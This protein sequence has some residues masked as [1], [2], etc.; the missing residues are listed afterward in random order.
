MTWCVVQSY[1][2]ISYKCPCN[3]RAVWVFWR[4][5]SVVC[6]PRRWSGL[7]QW[8]LISVL[9]PPQLRC[10]CNLFST[11]IRQS[12]EHW[13]P[14][15]RHHKCSSRFWR[16]RWMSFFSTGWVTLKPRR[17]S[18]TI[19]TSLKMD[20]T[21]VSVMEMLWPRGHWASTRTTT[22]HPRRT[23]RRR[24]PL[25]LVPP[26]APQLTARYR[27]AAAAPPEQLEPTAE[28]YGGLWA[29]RR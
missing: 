27:L 10:W 21:W 15:C 4:S 7:S 2:E 6:V 1:G 3:N 11:Q 24:S 28:F 9:S 12:E 25:P 19:C 14:K 22:W 17:C 18:K 26:A 16:W 8:S 29:P 20:N 13:S 5:S 23:W